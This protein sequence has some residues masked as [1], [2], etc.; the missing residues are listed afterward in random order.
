MTL[1]CNFKEQE[2]RCGGVY[3]W[4]VGVGVYVCMCGC[5]CGGVCVGGCEILILSDTSGSRAIWIFDG[6]VS[7]TAATTPR[8]ELK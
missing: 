3:V 4:C 8:K 5:G 1:L 7:E 6:P 2:K